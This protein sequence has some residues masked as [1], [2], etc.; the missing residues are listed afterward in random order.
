M[1]YLL[2][3]LAGVVV[4]AVAGYLVLRA[5]PNKKAVVDDFTAKQSSRLKNR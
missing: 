5:N 2:V 4:G 1:T 3:L